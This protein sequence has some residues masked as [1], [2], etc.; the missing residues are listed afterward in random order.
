MCRGLQINMHVHTSINVHRGK[1]TRPA[2]F[3]ASCRGR[4]VSVTC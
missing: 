4:V 3:R 1:H 2:I